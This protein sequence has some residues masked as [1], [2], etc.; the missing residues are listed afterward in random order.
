MRKPFES[1]IEILNNEFQLRKSKKTSQ[2][3]CGHLFVNITMRFQSR[4]DSYS[5]TAL[6][7]CTEGAR[8]DLNIPQ[9]GHI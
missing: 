1:T 4:I 5:S 6:R 2:N 8:Q 7:F 9:Q 3:I